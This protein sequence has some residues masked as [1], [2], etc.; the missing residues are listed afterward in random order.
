MPRKSAETALRLGE[1]RYRALVTATAQV[2]WTSDGQ[3]K[4]A[5]DQESWGAFTGQSLAEIQ[6]DGWISALHPDDR[7]PILDIWLKAV[8]ARTFHDTEFRRRRH[9]GAYRFMAVRA[10]PV[11]EDDGTIR[12][13]I[14]TCADITERPRKPIWRYARH[15]SSRPRPPR[16]WW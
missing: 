10:V 8:Q 6:S 9:D 2:V 13:W 5:L 16:S 14:G 1:E 7:E 15:W 11:L 4:A 12:E 3:S